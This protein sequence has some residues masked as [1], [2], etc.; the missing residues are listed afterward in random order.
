M[1]AHAVFQRAAAHGGDGRNARRLISRQRSGKQ[2]C[3]NA[4]QHAFGNSEGG[5]RRIAHGAH[6]V[7][8]VD[9]LRY[10]A[11]RTLPQH[12]AQ[13]HTG[14]CAHGGNDSCFQ[15]HKRKQLLAGGAQGAQRA[16]HRAALH[17]RK[18]HRVVNEKHAHHQ[19]QQAERRQ[20]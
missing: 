15:H 7:Q 13:A 10:K 6:V 14:G 11:H 17:H 1:P 12:P 3:A 9:G 19:S 5:Q 20:V 2:A 8:V 16:K 18:H 4:Q